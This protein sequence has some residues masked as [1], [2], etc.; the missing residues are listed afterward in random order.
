M[1]INE[2][3]ID[4]IDGDHVI[5]GG[6]EDDFVMGE[7]IETD[8]YAEVEM[9]IAEP[10]K[11]TDVDGSVVIATPGDIVTIKSESIKRFSK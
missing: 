8:D 9:E 6:Y 3:E 10:T 2:E 1:R 7:D 11:L 4:I 5:D